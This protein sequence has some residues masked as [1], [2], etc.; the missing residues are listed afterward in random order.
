MGRIRV[1]MQKADG[2]TAHAVGDQSFDLAQ[3]DRHVERNFDG[4]VGRQTFWNLATP[5]TRHERRGDSTSAK[6]AVVISPVGAPLRSIR[7]L[8]NSV[9]AWTT[10]P[11]RSGAIPDRSTSFQ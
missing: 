6:P 5:E 8:V 2:E 4:A 1:G 10:L 11:M 3:D 9:V 7:A